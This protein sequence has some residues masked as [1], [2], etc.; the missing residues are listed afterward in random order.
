MSRVA[1]SFAIWEGRAYMVK[2]VNKCIVLVI[3]L[4][5]GIT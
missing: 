2:L 4:L 3:I 1:F 5:V